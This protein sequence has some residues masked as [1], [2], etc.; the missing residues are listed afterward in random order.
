MQ[1]LRNLYL[2]EGLKQTVEAETFDL[3][4]LDAELTRFV[5]AKHLKRLAAAGFRGEVLFP[6]PYLIEVN[7]FLL[8]YYRLLLGFSQK[9]FYEQGPFSR[10]KRL[11]EKGQIAAAVKTGIL[12]LCKSLLQSAVLLLAKI[13]PITLDV[14]NDL[15]VLTLGPQLRGSRN[16]DTGQNAVQVMVDLFARLLTGYSP[17][18]TRR[19]FEFKN[20]SGHPLRIHFG[21]D[22][23]VGVTVQ[24]GAVDRKLVAIEIKG[25]T[26]ISNI[27]NRLGEAEKSH[28]TAR[29]AGYNEL[30]TVTGVD[31]GAS[32]DMH[33]TAIEKSPSTTKFFFLPQIAEI[34]S[35]QGALF[36][37]LLGSIMGVKLDP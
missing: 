5:P 36:R 34:Q 26:D 3:A 27:W 29:K 4:R 2:R 17:T 30:W 28:Q 1:S 13:N 14:V 7:P 21:G 19:S 33:A 6:V 35:P 23:D 11:E 32:A 10:F 18:M 24:L 25:G 12:P 20:D 16:V 15:Q 37:Q 9:A 31:V 8:G 22:P